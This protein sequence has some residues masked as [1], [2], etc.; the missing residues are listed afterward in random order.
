MFSVYFSFFWNI[1]LKFGI[2]ICPD[3][4]QIKFYFR[5]TWYFYMSY[6]SLLKLSFSDFHLFA[7]V[8]PL[9]NLLG[10]VRD[11]YCFSNTSELNWSVIYHW[12]GSYVFSSNLWS[13]TGY[14]LGVCYF[15]WPDCK[16]IPAYF[17]LHGHPRATRS[18]SENYKMQKNSCPTRALTCHSEKQQ[19]TWA[20]TLNWQTAL[21]QFV[22]PVRL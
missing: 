4:I 7:E 22:H 18:W 9:E 11:L 6:C 5:S 1:D 12:D 19:Y 3:V 13:K 15:C 21:L 16:A 10:P 14:W 17:D 2:W 8:M 20:A